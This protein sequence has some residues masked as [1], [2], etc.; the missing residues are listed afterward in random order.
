MYNL[1]NSADPDE[2]SQELF[3]RTKRSPGT[4]VYLNLKIVN[5]DP[6]IYTMNHSRLIVSIKSC[7]GLVDKSLTLYPGQAPR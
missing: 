1:A 5:C 2:I 3:A 4:E 6:L 7:H